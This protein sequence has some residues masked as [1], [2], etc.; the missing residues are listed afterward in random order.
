LC[1]F[2]IPKRLWVGGKTQQVSP[3]EGGVCVER[4]MKLVSLSSFFR[5]RIF[6]EAS[7][8][9]FDGFMEDDRVLVRNG[10]G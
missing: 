3:H 7:S 1:F 8:K 10:E 5:S 2:A 9:R 4:K 6:Y